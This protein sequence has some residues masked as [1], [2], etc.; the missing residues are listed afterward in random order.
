MPQI[1]F[2]GINVEKV[3]SFSKELV[4]QLHDAV[5]CPRDYFTLE[6]FPSTYIFDGQLTDG[7][8]FVE[9]AW[10]DRGHETQDLVAQLITKH[11]QGAGYPDV[12]IAFLVFNP[13]S[14][15]ENGKHF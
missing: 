15:Y 12:D 8:P 9:V 4:D 11:V 6:C 3:C 14:Y 10:F 5:G 7:Y 13:S 1:K 2:R